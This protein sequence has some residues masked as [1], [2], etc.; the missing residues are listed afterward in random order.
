[1]EWRIHIST[2][3]IPGILKYQT[4]EADLTNDREWLLELTKQLH[5]TRSISVGGTLQDYNLVN[6]SSQKI[7]DICKDFLRR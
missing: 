6:G 1:M 4:K 3:L 2:E 5:K 7:N